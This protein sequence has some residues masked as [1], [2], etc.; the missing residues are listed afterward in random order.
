MLEAILFDTSKTFGHCKGKGIYVR[1]QC[2]VKICSHGNQQIESGHF[3][4]R[5]TQMSGKYG[6]Q[7]TGYS[8]D[9]ALAIVPPIYE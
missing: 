6:R 3:N 2:H 4:R 5:K 7:F 1:N 9:A 8:V